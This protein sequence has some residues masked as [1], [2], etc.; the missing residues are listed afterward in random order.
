MDLDFRPGVQ[1]PLTERV[2]SQGFRLLPGKALSLESSIASGVNPCDFSAGLEHMLELEVK[3]PAW[4]VN[5]PLN[6]T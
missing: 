3:L 5:I 6:L 4:T 1:P 2:F